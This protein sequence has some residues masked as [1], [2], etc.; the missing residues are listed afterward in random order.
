MI[1]KVV[2]KMQEEIAA[3]E[4]DP[5]RTPS[6]EATSIHVHVDDESEDEIDIRSRYDLLYF[7]Y[8]LR[9]KI[10]TFMLSERIRK[11]QLMCPE[12]ETM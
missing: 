2:K 4:K 9:N 7:R 12:Q 1:G 10:L 11:M 8:R 3:K 6:D 5:Q